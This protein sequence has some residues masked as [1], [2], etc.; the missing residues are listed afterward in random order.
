V[1][2]KNVKMPSPKRPGTQ[3]P[4]I[5]PDSILRDHHHLAAVHHQTAAHHHRLAAQYYGAGDPYSALRHA[6]EAHEH[7]EL[8]QLHNVWAGRPRQI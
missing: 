6:A 3:A 7:G 1:S 4:A 8:A 2:G 5:E